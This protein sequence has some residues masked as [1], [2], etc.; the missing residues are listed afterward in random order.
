M[1]INKDLSN[2]ELIQPNKLLFV[3]LKLVAIVFVC[4]FSFGAAIAVIPMYIKT[5]LQYSGLVIGFM[6]ALQYL[7]TLLSRG[8]AGNIAD[9][10]G[11]KTAVKW[12]LLTA[13]ACGLM[14]AGCVMS[15]STFSKLA[16]IAVGRII[17]GI[18]ESLI[19]TGTLAWALNQA[20]SVHA[21][22]IMAW[23]GNAMYGGVALGALGGGWLMSNGGFLW[24]TYVAIA[25]PL[26]ALLSAQTLQAQPVL[27]K[28]RLPFY[29]VIHS[30]AL[31]GAGL[32]LATVGYGVILTFIG[33]FF[34]ANDWPNPERGIAIFG[35]AYVVA[36]LLFSGLPDRHGGAK[37][38]FY[39]MIIECLGQGLIFISTQPNMV[40]LGCLLSGVGFS[41]VVPSLGLE[42][43][44]RT[45]LQNR[46]A[47]MGGF[48]AFFDLSFCIAIPLAGA[49]TSGNNYQVVYLIG[50]CAT[51]LGVWIA[52]KLL[53]Y[54]A[55][56][57][58]GEELTT[59]K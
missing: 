42:A 2:S 4:F 40:L 32:L 15:H 16:F 23:N 44:K 37:V 57:K 24:I 45:P 13:V 35:A 9:A 54:K 31:P 50:T 28:K 47:A 30:I 20:G 29:K 55:F 21:G 17:L 58:R 56:V 38:A 5:E 49:V 19:I 25:L 7:S 27:D 48:L 3:L 52:W 41:L 26:I 1:Q 46:G 8:F 14:Y 36:R 43:I 12:G 18:S 11:A 39:S 34:Q 33:L 10:V 6:I 53:P 51:L 22:K 59:D